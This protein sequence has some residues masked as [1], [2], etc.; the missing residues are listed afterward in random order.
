MDL[1]CEMFV[2]VQHLTFSGREFQR[3]DASYILKTFYHMKTLFLQL[4]GWG[5]FWQKC[6]I[7]KQKLKFDGIKL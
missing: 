7:R 4:I 1:N 5:F 3:T 6:C 2:F